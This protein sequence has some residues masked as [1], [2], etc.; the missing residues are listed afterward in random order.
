MGDALERLIVEAEAG[1]QDSP[2]L[3]A[4]EL[5]QRIV[6][7]VRMRRR[8]RVGVSLTLLAALPVAVFLVK[9]TET[10]E[11]PLESLTAHGAAVGE[12]ISAGLQA[13]NTRL[14]VVSVAP[15]RVDE[16]LE[17]MAHRWKRRAQRAAQAGRVDEARRG[18]AR[19]LTELPNT[20]PAESARAALAAIAAES[21]LEK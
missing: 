16:T 5:A 10:R 7:R 4:G 6:R 12:R 14:E 11:H 13:L 21:E 8:R 15:S 18:Y 9:G 20:T 17:W 1:L 2:Q 19:I 3:A